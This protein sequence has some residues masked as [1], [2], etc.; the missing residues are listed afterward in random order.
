MVEGLS[1]ATADAVIDTNAFNQQ[2]VLGANLQGNTIDMTVVG[3]DYHA[4]VIGHDDNA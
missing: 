3:G 4:D 1:Q 2:I